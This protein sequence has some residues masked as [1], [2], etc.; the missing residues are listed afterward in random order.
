MHEHI[1]VTIDKCTNFSVFFFFCCAFKFLV[2][3]ILD[4]DTALSFKFGKVIGSSVN[5]DETHARPHFKLVNKNFSA[6][7][8]CSSELNCILSKVKKNVFFSIKMIKFNE[9]VMRT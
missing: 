2:H 4:A 7:V 1:S 9:R 6:F 3:Q 5:C 8:H